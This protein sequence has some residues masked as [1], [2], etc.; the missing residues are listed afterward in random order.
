[1]DPNSST[2]NVIFLPLSLRALKSETPKYPT[3]KTP[4]GEFRLMPDGEVDFNGMNITRY[5][6]SPSKKW[7]K[8]GDWR[9]VPITSAC[10]F[11]DAALGG[12]GRAA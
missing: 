7:S 12:R 5:G 11:R 2:V 6:M 9:D 10:A 4:R 3:L 8:D 1:M